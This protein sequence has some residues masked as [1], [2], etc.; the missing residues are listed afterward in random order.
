MKK[1][2]MSGLVASIALLAFAYVCLMLMPVLLP[3]VAEEYFHP[4][5]SRDESRI[6]IY[7]VHPVVLAFA[8]AWFWNRFKDL[9]TGSL[10]FRGIEFGF[11]YG[12]ISTLP[13]MILTYSAMD[14]SLTVVSTWLLYGFFQGVIAGLIFARMHV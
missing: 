1:I 9:F 10:I 2:L 13:I 6:V 14:V 5:F 8:L 7:F 3:K 4:A 11:V 12:I